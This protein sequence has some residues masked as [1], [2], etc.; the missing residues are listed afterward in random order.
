MYSAQIL[1]TSFK[2]N[3]KKNVQLKFITK[4]IYYFCSNYLQNNSP[5]WLVNSYSSTVSAGG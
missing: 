1:N 4:K 5:Y 2:F 3:E